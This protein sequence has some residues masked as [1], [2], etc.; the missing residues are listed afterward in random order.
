MLAASPPLL[1]EGTGEA[2]RVIRRGLAVE[3]LADDGSLLRPS[4]TAP[5]CRTDGS[6]K[7]RQGAASESAA[8]GQGIGSSA[9]NRRK[10][11]SVIRDTS[12]S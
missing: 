6:H 1:A 3:A 7:G 10:T 12:L 5:D 11:F 8:S 9:A 2:T 4:S